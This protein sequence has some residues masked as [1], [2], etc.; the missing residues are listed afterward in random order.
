MS[1]RSEA[2]R[3]FC[4]GGGDPPPLRLVF[5]D[6][7]SVDLAP[8]PKVTVELRSPRLLRPLIGGDF[9]ALAKAYIEGEIVVHGSVEDILQTGVALA[10]LI[11]AA[12]A[13]RAL[14]RLMMALA[15]IGS[16][17]MDASHA[18]YQYDAADE[19]YRLWLDKRMVYSCAY[20]RSGAEDI[21]TA[22][23]QKLD[24]ICRKLLLK[25]GER[26]L[27]I[28]CG[29]GGLLRWA[30]QRRGVS[31]L[32]VTLSERQYRYARALAGND[33][34]IRLQDYR[35]VKEAPFDKIV[36]I[37]VYEHVGSRHLAA[38]FQKVS[39]LLRPGGAFLNQGMVAKDSSR[40]ARASRGGQLDKYL[41]PGG[42]LAPLSRV[43]FE[44][45]GAGLEVVDV[46]DLRPH[47]IRT[48]ESWSRRLEAREE[49]AIRTAGLERY[50][51]WRV[52]LA[53]MAEAFERGSL[54]VAQLLIYKPT[55]SRS[56]YRP[57]TRD[58]QY[59]GDLDPPAPGAARMSPQAPEAPA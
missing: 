28:G 22:Q 42:A 9:G 41:F 57:W 46:E 54:S 14:L 13:P 38:Y 44:A 1:L 24:H 26:L 8:S 30:S 58:Y 48:L 10:A 23:E 2:L 52:Y 7:E 35:D 25:P 33:V 12:A 55:A 34:E 15:R 45:A 59:D 5:W 6:H 51:I 27:D 43:I 50:R 17:R 19:F 3:L 37:D 4:S 16:G 11:E 40:E 53:G 20:F 18:R 36:S 56:G 29:W 21:D 39:A 31:G 32:G 49:E 47:Y